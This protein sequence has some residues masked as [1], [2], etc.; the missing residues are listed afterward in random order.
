MCVIVRRDAL[1]MAIARTVRA[2]FEEE[3]KFNCVTSL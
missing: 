1:M 2:L 3:A